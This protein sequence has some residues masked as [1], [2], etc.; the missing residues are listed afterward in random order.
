MRTD[1]E[2]KLKAEREAKFKPQRIAN[3]K[4]KFVKTAAEKEQEAKDKETAEKEVKHRTFERAKR[5]FYGEKP[6]VKNPWMDSIGGT[7]FWM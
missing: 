6:I 5:D 7:M 4:G 2:E 3:K 1:V